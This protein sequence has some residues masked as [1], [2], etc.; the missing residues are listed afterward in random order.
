M[1]QLPKVIGLAAIV[2]AVVVAYYLGF[3]QGKKA[4]KDA[5]FSEGKR[6]GSKRGFLV[7]YDRGKRV[8]EEKLDSDEESSKSKGCAIVFLLAAFLLVAATL[9]THLLA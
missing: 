3:K 6:E 9:A 2:F 5:G 4:G 7:G 1:D 8:R